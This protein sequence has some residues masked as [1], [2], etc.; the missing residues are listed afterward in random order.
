MLTA[1]ERGRLQHLEAPLTWLR[2][3]NGWMTRHIL[4]QIM[5]SVRRTVRRHCPGHE[6][7]LLLDSAP[8]HVH[9]D[10]LA[11]AARLQMHIVFVPSK[12]TWLLQPLDTHVFGPLK[13]VVHA[14]QLVQRA[15]HQHGHLPGGAWLDALQAGVQDIFL[16][17]SWEH[18]FRDNGLLEHSRPTRTM[19]ANVCGPVFPV[20]R[21]PPETET[22]QRLV[23]RNVERLAA[24][25]L[26]RSMRLN[27]Q[28]A[29]PAVEVEPAALGPPPLP[30]PLAPPEDE[31]IA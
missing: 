12:T 31:V 8:Q 23:G 13:T 14:H 29:A 18:A 27:M 19:L 3:T 16:R 20:P 17:R 1:A 4:C 24:R 5:T 2:G 30:P 11:H 6:M 22:L 28:A 10:V 9:V 26:S 15:E 21:T 25:A 7:V